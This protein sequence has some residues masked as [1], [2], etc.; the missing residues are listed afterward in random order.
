MNGVDT[1]SKTLPEYSR[2]L[3][4]LDARIFDTK[5]NR[6]LPFQETTDGYAVVTLR[7]DNLKRKTFKVHRLVAL[8]FVPNPENKETVN[9]INGVKLDNYYLNLEWA[10]R[11]EQTQ[12]AWDNGLVRNME[13]RKN[14]IREKQG[15]KVIC[16]TT[17]EI[18]NSIGAAAEAK[19]LSKSNLSA[20]CLKKPQCKTAG[21]LPDGTKLEWSFYE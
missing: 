12:H 21:K 10:T 16:L 17:G 8:C 3:I 18:Y 5:L 1:Q 13:K 19:G 7:A 2:Y 11:A 14:G 15:K 4:S 9:H 6:Y 20:V